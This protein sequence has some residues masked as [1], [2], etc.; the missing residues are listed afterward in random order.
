MTGFARVVSQHRRSLAVP[1]EAVT[2]LSAGKG[3]VRTVDAAG[4]HTSTLVSL[5]SVDDR[6]VE[7]TDGLDASAWVLT[8][9]PRFLR[10]EDK[11]DVT[12]LVASE[13]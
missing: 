2:A 7:I 1:R 12:R 3:T 10:D 4:R 6:F 11:I 5:G 8:R 13:P 9:N